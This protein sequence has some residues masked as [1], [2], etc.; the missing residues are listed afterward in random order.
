MVPLCFLERPIPFGALDG[1]PVH[2]LFSLVCPTV[3]GHLQMLARLSYALHDSKFKQIVLRHGQRDE[4]LQEARRIESALSAQSSGS[5]KGQ[6]Q[7]D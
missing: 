1:Q 6:A 5:E 2:V 4:I 7:D 3:R